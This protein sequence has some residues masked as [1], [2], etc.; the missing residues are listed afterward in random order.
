MLQISNFVFIK[1]KKKIGTPMPK[2]SHALGKKSNRTTPFWFQRTMAMIYHV[3]GSCLNFHCHVG[4]FEC[5]HSLILGAHLTHIFYS[6]VC[7]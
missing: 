4:E 6:E 3:E 7:Q 1:K 2:S 5:C